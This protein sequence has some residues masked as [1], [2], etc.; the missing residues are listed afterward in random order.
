MKIV[1]DKISKGIDLQ[2]SKSEVTCESCRTGKSTRLPFQPRDE[3]RRAKEPGRILHVDLCGPMQTASVHGKR[4]AMP[5][6]DE[7][8]RFVTVYFLTSKDEA[9]DALLECIQMYKTQ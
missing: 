6:I 7:F 2:N 9:A 3:S 5:I 1:N 8:S 4:Y